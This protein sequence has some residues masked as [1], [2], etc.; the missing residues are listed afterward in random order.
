ML[1]LRTALLQ[2]ISLKVVI[3]KSPAAAK[4]AS[5]F[6]LF[7]IELSLEIYLIDEHS[8]DAYIYPCP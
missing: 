3:F 7:T 4:L 6:C 1:M 5:S 8:I 2:N